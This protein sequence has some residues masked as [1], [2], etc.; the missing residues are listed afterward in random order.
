MAAAAGEQLSF[1]AALAATLEDLD[2]CFSLREEQITLLK[3]FLSKKDVFGVLPTGY[4][5]YVTFFVALIGH[6]AILL[7]AEAF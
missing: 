1:E 3:S 2:L 5:N 7:R 6:S 4:G